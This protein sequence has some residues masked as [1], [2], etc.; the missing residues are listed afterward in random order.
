MQAI[1]DKI[2][3]IKAMRKAKAEAKAEEKAEKELAKAR[4]E[5]AHEVRLAREAEASMDLH[6]AKASERVDKEIAKY[7]GGGDSYSQQ[8]GGLDSSYD[9]SIGGGNPGDIGMNPNPNAPASRPAEPHNPSSHQL[10]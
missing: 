6:V 4:V 7:S 5:V 3:D 10:L 9:P 8:P 1:R 2:N